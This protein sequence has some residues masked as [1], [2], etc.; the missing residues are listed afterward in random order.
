MNYFLSIIMVFTLHACA[1]YKGV[2]LSAVTINGK[3]SNHKIVNRYPDYGDGHA[4][5]CLILAEMK[6]VLYLDQQKLNISGK[7]TDVV[8]AEIMRNA[9]I[10]L[11]MIDSTEARIKTDENG[12]FAFKANTRIQKVSFWSIAYRTLIIKL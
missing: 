4:D 5:G 6:A 11:T 9:D 2:T 8:N 3:K 10:T 1:T 12:A 7:L